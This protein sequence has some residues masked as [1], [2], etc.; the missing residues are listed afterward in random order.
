MKLLTFLLFLNFFTGFSAIA[1]YGSYP[2]VFLVDTDTT[3]TNFRETPNG[4][5][6]CRL[7]TNK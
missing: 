2:S 3:G 7:V 6:L 1:Q 4:K 5:I